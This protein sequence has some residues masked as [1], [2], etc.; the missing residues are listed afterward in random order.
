MD[1]RT[2]VLNVYAQHIC[3]FKFE[4]T[5]NIMDYSA[6]KNI[7]M[8]WQWNLMQKDIVSYYGLKVRNSENYE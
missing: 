4:T 2:E 3:R 6:S 7:F 8:S 1:K 5:K